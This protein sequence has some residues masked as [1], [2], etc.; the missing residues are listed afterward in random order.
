M[1]IQD[2]F[3]CRKCGGRELKTYDTSD[4]FRCLKCNAHFY[5]LRGPQGL[6]L[7]AKAIHKMGSDWYNNYEH[8]SGVTLPDVPEFE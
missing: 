4:Q 7:T 1:R 6:Q 8:K 2:Y 5:P 3:K